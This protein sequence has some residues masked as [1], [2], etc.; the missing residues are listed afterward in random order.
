MTHPDLFYQP[1]LG[2][3][4]GLPH[5]PIKSFVIPRPIGWISTTSPSGQD[6]LAPFSQFTNVSFDPPTILFV[7]HQS[8][9]KHR[10]RDTVRNAI[11]TNEFVW[12]M[13][14][15][16]QRGDVNLTGLET[17]GDEFDESGIEK[18]ASVLVRPPRVKNSPVSF[19]CRVHSILRVA[20]EHYGKDAAGA[21]FVGNSDIVVGRVLGIHVKGEYID[22]EG[23]FDVLKAMPL[24]RNGYRQYTMI[25][26]V[27]DIEPVMMPDD[28]VGEKEEKVEEKGKEV[29]G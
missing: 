20:N 15:Y 7:A 17:W 2:E 22:G 21:H 29:K 4:S 28:T 9:Y 1:P 19:E 13:A 12:N 14:T 6:N 26:S 25:Q 5:D 10:Q 24:A 23:L 27:F 16:E 18:E 8:L 11:A 3:T